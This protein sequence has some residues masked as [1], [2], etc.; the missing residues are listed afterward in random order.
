VD[1]NDPPTIVKRINK[2]E[3]SIFEE[4]VVI[5]DVEIDEVTARKTL[6]APSLEII[7]K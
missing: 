4:Y 7:K 5:P 2:S 1:I 3:T 6:A